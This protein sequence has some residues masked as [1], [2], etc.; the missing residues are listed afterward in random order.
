M[1]SSRR[2]VLWCLVTTA[3][4]LPASAYAQAEPNDIGV[5]FDLAGSQTS[6]SP[7]LG[8]P[9]EFWIT[10]F[11]LPDILAYEMCVMT[12]PSLTIVDIT[13]LDPHGPCEVCFH[14]CWI[15]VLTECIDAAAVHP[16]VRY[17]AYNFTT[18][19]ADALICI[20]PYRRSSFVPPAP[21][22]MACTEELI[23]F[24][25]AENGQGIYPDGCGVLYPTQ[26]PPLAGDVRSW[27]ALKGQFVTKGTTPE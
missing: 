9:F 21:G 22:Y 17:T 10:A 24:G 27:G 2:I 12:P 25:V 1:R 23:P 18:D 16:L 11:D 19:L 6:A 26:E 15:T 3:V 8:V 5:L 20:E 7:A 13:I 4:A 14:P